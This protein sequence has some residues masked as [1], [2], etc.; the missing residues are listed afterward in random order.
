MASSIADRVGICIQDR[1]RGSEAWGVGKTPDYAQ[2]RSIQAT[3]TLI[4]AILPGPILL[5]GISSQLSAPRT[6]PWWRRAAIT[7]PGPKRTGRRVAARRGTP[8]GGR[9]GAARRRRGRR[10]GA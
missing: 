4:G 8:A 3:E 7:R 10:T 5:S 2:E 1:R 9:S 6:T